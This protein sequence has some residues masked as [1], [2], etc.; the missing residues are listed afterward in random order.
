MGRT[1]FPWNANAGV[2][3]NYSKGICPVVE[4]MYHQE[5]IYT[6]LIR[7]PLTEADIDDFVTAI[8][9]VLSNLDELNDGVQD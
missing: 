9:K 4:H 7:E 2:E 3:Y 1:G 8:K 6:P 5:L